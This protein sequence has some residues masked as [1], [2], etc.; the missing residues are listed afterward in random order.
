M[1]WSGPALCASNGRARTLVLV[2]LRD[3]MWAVLFTDLIGSTAQRARLGDEA[4]DVLRREHDALVSRALGIHRGE[5]VDG[6]GDGAMCVFASAADA[7]AAGVAI[8]QGIERRNR[9]S[10]E[11]LGLRVGVSAGELV[12]EGEGLMGLAAHEA[13]RICSLCEAGEVLISD[14]VR[15]MAGSRTDAELVE[16]GAF[17]LKG[18]PMPVTVWEVAWTPTE[19]VEERLAVPPRLLSPDAWI[20]S[21]RATEL[22][23]LCELWREALA[24][25]RR[26]VFI[27]GEP[28][29]GKTR[30]AAECARLACD[31]GALVLYGQCDD[32]LG[33]PFLPFAEAL[34]WYLEH[35]AEVLAGRFPGD[36][37]R[38]SG[39]VRDRVPGAGDPLAADAETEQRRLFDAVV[40]WLCELADAQ[41]VVLVL[42]DVHWATKPTLRM[43]RHLLRATDGARLLVVATYRDT[44]LDRTHPLAGMLGDFRRVAGVER[45][46]LAGLDEAGVLEFLGNA[47]G[48]RVDDRIGDL[49][50]ALVAETEGN[51]FFLGEVLRHL[52]ESGA[53][54]HVDDRWTSDRSIDDLGLPEG[55]REVVGQRLDRLGDAANALLTI[56][57]LV[58]RDFTVAV[59]AEVSGRP[60]DDVLDVLDEAVQARII[61]EIALDRFRFS[62]ALVR[63]TLAD[64][65]G[66]SRRLRLHRRIAEVFERVDPTNDSAL[67]HHWLEAAEAGDPPRAI[68]YATRAAESA[69]DA[70]AYDDAV[71]LYRR[72]LELCEDGDLEQQRRD[73]LVDLATT[74]FLVGA[75][76]ALDTTVE[77]V[78]AARAADDDRNLVRGATMLGWNSSNQLGD[79]QTVEVMMDALVRAGE[80]MPKERARLLSALTH[81]LMFEA[82]DRRVAYAEEALD[83]A[84]AADDPDLFVHVSVAY[85]HAISSPDNLERRLAIAHEAQDLGPRLDNA[86]ARNNALPLQPAW[87]AGDLEWVRRNA[88]EEEA[89]LERVPYAG[90]RAGLFLHK[91]KNALFTGYLADAERSL[92]DLATG[93]GEFPGVF[94]GYATLIGVLRCEQ[95]RAVEVVELVARLRD[96]LESEGGLEALIRSFEGFLALQAG[97]GER[98][99]E[100]LRTEAEEHFAGQARDSGW[101]AYQANWAESAAEVGD[102][103]AAGQLH[104]LLVPFVDRLANF[105]AVGLGSVAR[106]VG[107]LETVLGM[108]SDAEQHLAH[109]EASHEDWSA[110]LYLARTWADQAELLLVRDGQDAAPAANALLERART[111]ARERDA[112]GV[113]QYVDRVLQRAR[114]RGCMV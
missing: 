110:A 43:L 1:R 100:M 96:R 99:A 77:A 78:E 61:E 58:G 107:R 101:Y 81:L 16:R 29:I 32:E 9:R 51:P 57:A 36:L 59:L 88:I 19:E 89:L 109:A 37:T 66:S 23:T 27:S 20:F 33:T 80:D 5:F 65:L 6:T 21:S 40:S 72:A 28:G 14:L 55:V 64:E 38:L 68:V 12:V 8:Q 48:E 73:L 95:G 87:E 103:D 70:G 104:A 90:G 85:L 46:A 98:A 93:Y 44:D 92:D 13:A 111:V 26:A 60:P 53:I 35:A 74:L 15:L 49:A 45:V 67:A 34:D 3:G 84:R 11:P 94:A 7:I 10:E 97:D 56:A 113:E 82:S 39:R 24:G 106:H 83:L 41:P 22:G 108:Y 102:G 50:A 62:H 2:A 4:G 105:V 63:A 30:L 112:L 31:E 18:I 76:N 75:P 79:T 25:A 86:I 69:A 17:E 54:V 71:H 42:D 91:A 47:A 52:V 114:E